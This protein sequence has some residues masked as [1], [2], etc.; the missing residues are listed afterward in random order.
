M[1]NTKRH[2]TLY[3]ILVLNRLPRTFVI[4]IKSFLNV[5]NVENISITKFSIGKN[6]LKISVF[7]VNT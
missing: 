7:K 4:F 1:A 2:K 3:N 5:M 6:V